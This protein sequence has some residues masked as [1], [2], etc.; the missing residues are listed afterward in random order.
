MSEFYVTS[1][2]KTTNRYDRYKDCLILKEKE[3]GIS[4]LATREVKEIPLKSSDT[5]HIVKSHEAS[6]LDLIAYNYYKNPLLWW[7]IAQ[8]NNIYNPIEGVPVGTTL[9]IPSLETLYGN[10][11][12]LL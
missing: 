12:I 7:V 8:A 11:G 6:R 4:Y 3:T 1:T 5:Y 2:R 10:H 9:R